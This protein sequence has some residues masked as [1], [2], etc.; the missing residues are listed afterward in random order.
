[1]S[2]FLLGA[3]ERW[4]FYPLLCEIFTSRARARFTA[5]VTEH[6]RSKAS[7]YRGDQ[8][9]TAHRRYLALSLVAS[10]LPI[11]SFA[12]NFDSSSASTG[13]LF[14]PS[15]DH[16]S[17]G[18]TAVLLDFFPPSVPVAGTGQADVRAEASGDPTNDAS[19]TACADAGSANGSGSGHS[20]AACPGRGR[21]HD[22]ALAATPLLRLLRLILL[23]VI[24]LRTRLLSLSSPAGAVTDGGSTALASSAPASFR[25][26]S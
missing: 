18:A 13:F 25:P 8:G 22:F 23:R 11:A 21:H 15:T 9:H 17:Q 2:S 7:Y 1:M 12:F 24:L 3:L 19:G 14:L 10:F 4:L 20:T 26:S 16:F 5:T 6:L